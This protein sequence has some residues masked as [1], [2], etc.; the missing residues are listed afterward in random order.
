MKN[1]RLTREQLNMFVRYFDARQNAAT[2]KETDAGSID[3]TKF[4]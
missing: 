4:H 3:Q 2:N 1:T